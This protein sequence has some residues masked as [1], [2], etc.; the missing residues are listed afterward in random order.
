ML[1]LIGEKKD[2]PYIFYIGLADCNIL[3]VY[4]ANSDNSTWYTN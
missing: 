1:D 4:L 2:I 3:K